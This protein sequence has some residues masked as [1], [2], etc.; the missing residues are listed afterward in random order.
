MSESR[1]RGQWLLG[2]LVIA[3]VV[4]VAAATWRFRRVKVTGDTAEQ[5]IASVIKIADDRPRGYA[6]AL[7]D[8][9]RNDPDA[10]VRSTA[11]ACL[12]GNWI[13]DVR[14]AV[15]EAT[16]DDDPQVRKSA[17]ISLMAYDDEATVQRLTT[18]CHEETN[19]DVRQ[20]AV[21]ALAANENPYAAVALMT[22]VE[23][24]ETPE[25]RRAAAKAMIDKVNIAVTELPEDQLAWDNM[26]ESFRMSLVVE[27]AYDQTGTPLVRDEAARHRLQAHHGEK[28]H[29]ESA[30]GGLSPEIPESEE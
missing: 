5:R 10:G 20:A 2:V 13:P 17:C 1:R 22:M 16:R 27:A 4:A 29:C 28:C 26:L 6:E 12:N 19:E 24:G 3:C 23:Q 11:L 7:A 30:P 8:T 14:S 9:A 18:I 15:V 21:L 25:L